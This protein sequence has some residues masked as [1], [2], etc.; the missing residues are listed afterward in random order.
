MACQYDEELPEM[1]PLNDVLQ[2]LVNEV[3]LN[4]ILRNKMSQ[5]YKEAHKK[6]FMW[7][8]VAAKFAVSIDFA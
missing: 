8:Q 7:A 3:Q 1:M 2:Q 4:L 5:E 6:R